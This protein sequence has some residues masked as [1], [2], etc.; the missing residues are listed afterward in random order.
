MLDTFLNKAWSTY[1]NN[2]REKVKA[3]T[4]WKGILWAITTYDFFLNSLFNLFFLIVKPLIVP[5]IFRIKQQHWFGWE[6]FLFPLSYKFVLSTLPSSNQQLLKWFFMTIYTV[7]SLY[8]CMPGKHTGVSGKNV[9]WYNTCFACTDTES[10]KTQGTSPILYGIHYNT[11]KFY[12][13][14]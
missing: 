6:D 10:S 4:S 1:Q 13:D 2:L 14:I 3:I 9:L 8:S 5:F 7:I 12:S 11:E